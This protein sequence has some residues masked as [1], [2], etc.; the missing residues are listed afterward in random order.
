MVLVFL[1]HFQLLVH[2]DVILELLLTLRQ[3]TTTHISDHIWEWRRWKRLIKTPIPPKII[4]E[5]F[6]KSLHPPI[7]KDVATS[8]VTTEE[9]G[10]FKSHQLDLIYAHSGMLYHILLDAPW[11]TYDPRQKLGPHADGIVGTV[12]VKSIESVKIHLKELSLNQFARGPSSSVSSN[13]THSEY[14]HYVQSS[15]NPNGNQKPGGNKKKGR[16]N[17]KGGKNGNKPKD[18]GNNEKTNNNAGEGKRERCK[19]KLPCKLCTDDHLTHLCPKLVEA[20]RL[21][22]LPLFVLTNPFPHN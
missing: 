13:P 9:E 21:L 3:D 1:N 4:L 20:T 5:W 15:T 16:N 2:Y 8:G 14:V 17:R 6:L 11:S 10:I 7:S 19:V 12:N 18:N 22:S